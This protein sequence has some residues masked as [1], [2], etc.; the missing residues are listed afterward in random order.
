VPGE[1]AHRVEETRGDRALVRGAIRGLSNE[2]R[3]IERRAL[4]RRQGRQHVRDRELE[5]VGEAGEGE[6]RLGLGR[7]RLENREAAIAGGVDPGAP[8]R[9]RPDPGLAGDQQPRRPLSGPPENGV[10]YRKLVLPGDDRKAPPEC[11]VSR[12]ERRH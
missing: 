11:I 8:D 1:G 6:L 3:R 12:S 7:A 4:G 9:R 10:D 2:Q 5:E